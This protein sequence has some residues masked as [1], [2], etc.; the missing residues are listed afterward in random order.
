[1]ITTIEKQ[2]SGQMLGEIWNATESTHTRSELQQTLKD[3]FTTQGEM[4]C[5]P[6]QLSYTVSNILRPEGERK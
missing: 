1:M 6:V 4:R 3:L 5:D 2:F